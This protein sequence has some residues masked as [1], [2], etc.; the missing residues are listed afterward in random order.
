MSAGSRAALGAWLGPCA[1]HGPREAGGGRRAALP[2]MAAAVPLPAMPPRIVR[3]AIAAIRRRA[4]FRAPTMPSPHEVA[5]P[6]SVAVL[7]DG[8]R[9]SL[10][11]L[12]ELAAGDAV[13]RLQGR[14]QPEPT[15]YSVQVG[16]SLHI[17]MPPGAATG[18]DDPAYQWRF[19]NHACEPNTAF[20]GWSEAGFALG[21]FVGPGLGPALLAVR[22]IAAGEELTFDYLTTEFDMAAPF[23]CGCG[24]PACVGEVAGYRRL[25]A[26]QRQARA[27]RTAAHVLRRWNEQGIS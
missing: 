16:A 8:N 4:T 20:V 14:L 18:D 10:V 23:L 13:L 12:R 27:L 1:P 2:G 6:P 9:R 17:E 25:V 22:A 15:R 7:L 26:T 21:D 24:S 19:L 11:A 3:P 5:V